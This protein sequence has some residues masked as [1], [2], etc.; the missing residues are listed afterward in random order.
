MNG[1]AAQHERSPY[2]TGSEKCTNL[3]S[4][5]D[6]LCPSQSGTGT[7]RYLDF[8][9]HT[10]WLTRQQWPA[11]CLLEQTGSA[12]TSQTRQEQCHDLPIVCSLVHDDCVQLSRKDP[13]TVRAPKSAQTW[14]LTTTNCLSS[15]PQYISCQSTLSPP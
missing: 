6:Q 10:L 5:Y 11:P 8:E 7:D 15:T 1:C 9:S 3:G 2:C 13:P 14:D 12:R 4:H